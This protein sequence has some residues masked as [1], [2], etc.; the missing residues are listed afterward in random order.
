M[1]TEFLPNWCI[2]RCQSFCCKLVILLELKDFVSTC[3]IPWASSEIAHGAVLCCH[4]G[5]V[6]AQWEETFTLVI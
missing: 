6:P 2:S 4:C 1:L 3:G 5:Y